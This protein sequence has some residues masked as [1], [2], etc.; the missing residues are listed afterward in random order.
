M[1]VWHLFLFHSSDDVWLI[2][3]ESAKGNSPESQNL[4]ENMLY[5]ASKG[6][7]SVAPDSVWLS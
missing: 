2:K 3:N 7:L 1:I 6:S 4:S 5:K